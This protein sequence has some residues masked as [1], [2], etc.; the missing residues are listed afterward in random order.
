M[1]AAKFF[2]DVYYSN[3][4]Y[5]RVGGV[6][7]KEI[8]LLEWQFLSLVNYHLYVSPREYDQYLKNVLAAV[9]AGVRR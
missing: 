7:T 2:D 6:R 4:F 9:N 3:A 8:N 5:A 1:L